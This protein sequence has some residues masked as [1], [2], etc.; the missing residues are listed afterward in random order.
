MWR[1]D[2]QFGRNETVAPRN[3]DSADGR[4]RWPKVVS[5]LRDVRAVGLTAADAVFGPFLGVSLSL[6]AVFHAKA[7]VA[8]ALM[9]LVPVLVIPVVVVAF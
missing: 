8:S 6:Y 3:G 1:H 2:P 7:G 9:S 5:G 4:M